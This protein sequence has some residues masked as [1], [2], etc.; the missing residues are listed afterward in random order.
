MIK[1]TVMNEPGLPSRS[2]ETIA[3]VTVAEI[4]KGDLQEG[5]DLDFKREVHVDKPEAKARLLDDVVIPQPRAGPARDW[6]GGEG[7]A[8]RQLPSP[9]G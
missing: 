1:V 7:R 8:L 6:G 2:P 3:P 4:A 5:Q 9:A